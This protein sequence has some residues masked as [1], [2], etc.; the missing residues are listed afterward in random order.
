MAAPAPSLLEVQHE[1]YSQNPAYGQAT[2]GL[3]VFDLTTNQ[4]IEPAAVGLQLDPETIP[5]HL[6]ER[7]VTPGHIRFLT[8]ALFNKDHPDAR[9]SGGFVNRDHYIIEHTT[10]GLRAPVVALQYNQ[11]STDEDQLNFNLRHE[12]DHL[13]TPARVPYYRRYETLDRIRA[14]ATFLTGTV[15]MEGVDALGRAVDTG[16]SPFSP[17]LGVL[18][19]AGFATYSVSQMVSRQGAMKF[20]HAIDP[21]ERHANRAARE[22]ADFAP[23][24]ILPQAT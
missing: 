9:T 19:L 21:G 22:H 10:G 12:L 23:L 2:P 17:T 1:L 15:V 13:L 4:F 7:G 18:A 5:T 6:I 20:V 16:A 8:L 24:R 3:R 11:G 14:T